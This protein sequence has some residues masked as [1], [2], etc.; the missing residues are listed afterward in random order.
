MDHD[1]AAQLRSFKEDETVYVKNIGP[2]QTTTG[3]VS[4]R[5]LLEGGRVWETPG[6]YE[7]EVGEASI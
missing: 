6:P 1:R 3:P 4:Y 2:G 5:V 7:T